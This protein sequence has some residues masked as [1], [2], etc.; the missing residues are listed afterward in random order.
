M[1]SAQEGAV[2]STNSSSISGTEASA[3]P[4]GRYVDRTRSWRPAR[5]SSRSGSVR[6][7]VTRSRTPLSTSGARAGMTRWVSSSAGPARCTGSAGWT[8]AEP[9]GPVTVARASSGST[10]REASSSACGA[11]ATPRASRWNSSRSSC[12]SS[13]RICV[14]TVGCDRPSTRAAAV[15]EPVRYTARNVRSRLRSTGATPLSWVLS[16]I[17]SE[18]LCLICVS[19]LDSNGTRCVP[20]GH[21]LTVSRKSTPCRRSF[22][23]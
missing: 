17:S 10:I 8:S 5:S 14:V 2:T 4:R 22:S 12:R 7:G 18:S 23:C 9:P 13:V 20:S 6:P 19:L 21:R 1:R 11:G 16:S 3:R 15:K